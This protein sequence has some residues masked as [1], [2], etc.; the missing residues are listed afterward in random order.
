MESHSP[1]VVMSKWSGDEEKPMETMGVEDSIKKEDWGSGHQGNRCALMAFLRRYCR[2]SNPDVAEN[3]LFA[4]IFS[5]THPKDIIHACSQVPYCLYLFVRVE[6]EGGR[7][8]SVVLIGYCDRCSG[9]SVLRLLKI[10]QLNTDTREDDDDEE[11]EDGRLA[12]NADADV[13]VEML[14]K[15]LLPLS[16]LAVFYCNAPY[17]T[18]GRI[19]EAR[20]Q[21]L[22]P[23]LLSLC[24]LPGA[25]Q[26]ALEAGLSSSTF[27]CVLTLLGD[28][29]RHCTA[30]VCHQP[31]RSKHTLVE[32]FH[33]LASYNPTQPAAENCASIMAAVELLVTSWREMLHYFKSTEGS[34]GADVG[35]I[36]AQL[37]DHKVKLHFLFLLHAMHP[38]RNMETLQLNCTRVDAQLQRACAVIAF[39]ATVVLEPMDAKLFLQRLDASKLGSKFPLKPEKVATGIG[40]A[41]RDFLCATAAVDL[42]EPDREEFLQSATTFYQ[43]VL[44]NL[45][46]SVPAHLGYPSLMVMSSLLKRPANTKVGGYGLKYVPPDAVFKL[47]EFS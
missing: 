39:Y 2:D 24:G 23:A 21:Q 8:T 17:T 42:S 11:E 25:A 26:R 32:A 27:G 35:R 33:C 40:R 16:N 22:C 7:R 38:L 10:L 37:M 47:V 14:E 45:V 43:S 46:Q 3:S 44:Q 36:T 18:L 13:L 19:L 31:D 12:E 34:Q 20:L 28:L 5:P 1:D 41:A 15:L 30:P 6:L 29:Q 4:D 9:R